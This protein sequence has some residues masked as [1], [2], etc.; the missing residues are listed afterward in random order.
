VICTSV[1]GSTLGKRLLSMQVI[2]D[3]GSSCRLKSATIRELGYFVDVMFFGA[4]G[5]FAMRNDPEH[6][7]HGDDWADTIVCKRA[8]APLASQQGAMRFVLGLAL[9]IAGDTAL[10]MTG[11]LIQIS[12]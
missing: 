4:I 10:L 7:R 5:Y 9:A 1:H 2:Q 8:H 3:D 6:K 11:F 12:F